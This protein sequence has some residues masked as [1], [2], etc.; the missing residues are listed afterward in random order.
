MKKKVLNQLIA[1]VLVCG[2]ILAV[3]MTAANA[4]VKTQT[5]MITENGKIYFYNGLGQ[6][7]TGWINISGK[8]YYLMR[9]ANAKKYNFKD[10]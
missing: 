6:K 9:M 3:G 8:W 10:K 7:E 1:A 5:G 4:E 2:S